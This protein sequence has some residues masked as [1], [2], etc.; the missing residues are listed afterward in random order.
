MKSK[1][2]FLRE[3][4]FCGEKSIKKRKRVRFTISGVAEFFEKEACIKTSRFWDSYKEERK[5]IY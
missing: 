1:R 5:I 4:Y 2:S 3:L